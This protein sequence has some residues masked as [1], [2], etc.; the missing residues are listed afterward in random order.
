M[1]RLYDIDW[2][3]WVGLGF[4]LLVLIY[5]VYLLMRI[6]AYFENSFAGLFM[7]LHLHEVERLCA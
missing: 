1:L 2:M 5:L 3:G 4:A 6:K 7:R